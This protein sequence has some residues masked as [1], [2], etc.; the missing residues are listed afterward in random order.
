MDE[1]FRPATPEDTEKFQQVKNLVLSG[2]GNTEGI[3]TLSEKLTH[4]LIKNFLTCDTKYH[5]VG[6]GNYVADVYDGDHIYEVQTRNFG[7]LKSKLSTFLDIAPVTVIYPVTVNNELNW[8]DPES[9]EIKEKRKSGKHGKASDIFKELVFIRDFMQD[10]NLDFWVMFFNSADYRLLDGYGRDN[11]KRASKLDRIPVEYLGDWKISGK[12]ELLEFIPD[13]LPEE[14]TAKDFC[15]NSSLNR[16]M[17]GKAVSVL[18]AAG[19]IEQ[20]GKDGRAYVYRRCG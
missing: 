10:P 19:L 13:T 16:D 3:G 4:R 9:G 11:K 7:K 17:A 1:F 8:I 14:F 15:E 12:Y 18:N 20:V 6:L 5:E 2:S